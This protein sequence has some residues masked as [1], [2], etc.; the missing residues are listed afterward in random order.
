M[1]PQ[2]CSVAIVS[3]IVGQSHIAITQIA[4]IGCKQNHKNS[5]F[6]LDLGTKVLVAA[7]V[8]LEKYRLFRR[9]KTE[10]FLLVVTDDHGC[11]SGWHGKPSA[12]AGWYPPGGNLR[13][14]AASLRE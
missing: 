4:V 14:S 1:A 3:N 9:Q 12:E 6:L 5:H 2:V 8:C 11:V 7:I 10:Y 13:V